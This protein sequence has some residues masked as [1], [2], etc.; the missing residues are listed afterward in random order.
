MD[1]HDWRRRIDELDEQLVRLLNERS[2]CAAE[3]GK[4]KRRVKQP[5]YQPERE[6]EILAR[7]QRM[8]GGPLGNEALKRLFE[9]I[10][11]E[12]RAVEQHTL[13]QEES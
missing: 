3:V 12:A 9:R 2:V 7:V 8:N 1:I 5:V 11:D 13:T 6:R 10:L 4:L